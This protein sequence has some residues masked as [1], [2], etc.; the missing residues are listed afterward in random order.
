MNIIEE[1]GKKNKR[2][3]SALWLWSQLNEVFIKYFVL[4]DYAATENKLFVEF[5]FGRI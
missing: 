4:K 3:I 1:K 2:K 5:Y